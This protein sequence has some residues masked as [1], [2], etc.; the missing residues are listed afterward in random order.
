MISR[1]MSML[2]VLSREKG[3]SVARQQGF[4]STSYLVTPPRT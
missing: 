1:N 4:A 2:I 3:G